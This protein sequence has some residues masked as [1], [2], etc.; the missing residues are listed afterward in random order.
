MQMSCVFKYILGKLP[1][2]TLIILIGNKIQLWYFTDIV[3]LDFYYNSV[4]NIVNVVI[5]TVVT[6]MNAALVFSTD[7]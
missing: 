5:L 7:M 1:V 6:N 3:T 4:E 2:N